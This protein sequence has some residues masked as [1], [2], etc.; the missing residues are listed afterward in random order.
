[1]MFVCL[2]S[3]L[4]V[5]NFYF[6]FSSILTSVLNFVVDV[7]HVNVVAVGHSFRSQFCCMEDV[8]FTLPV[9]DSELR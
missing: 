4:S 2:L 3:I 8:L 7:A 5:A 1:M 6:Y 9:G